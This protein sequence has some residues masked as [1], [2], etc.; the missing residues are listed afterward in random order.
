MK[1]K[2]LK[3]IITAALCAAMA[4]TAV[5]PTSTVEAATKTS[6]SLSRSSKLSD[7]A[8]E[9]KYGMTRNQVHCPLTI[10][11]Y[12]DGKSFDSSKARTLKARYSMPGMPARNNIQSFKHNMFKDAKI[13]D[14]VTVGGEQ[15]RYLTS[16]RLQCADDPKS[17]Y[18][19]DVAI[20]TDEQVDF[21]AY[22]IVSVK[23]GD[24][25]MRKI[26]GTGGK[27]N[28]IYS[29]KQTCVSPEEWDI[30]VMSYVVEDGKYAVFSVPMYGNKYSS[31][32]QVTLKI[33]AGGSHTI[34]VRYEDICEYVREVELDR[35]N[36]VFKK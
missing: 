34:R 11:H 22:I 28:S 6:T 2:L 30:D 13:G 3:S 35:V 8:Y 16:A 31:D 20:V 17:W 14:I 26:T 21:G 1:R 33:K 19:Y 15:Y 24:G 18:K 23:D 10:S 29:K 4:L 27:S 5:A 9:K 12:T 32:G 7:K 25:K 36:Y